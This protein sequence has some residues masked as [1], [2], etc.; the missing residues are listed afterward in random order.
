MTDDEH[1][2]TPPLTLRRDAAVRLFRAAMWRD[3]AA[4]WER[5]TT[6]RQVGRE[7]M[8]SVG[9]PDKAECIRRAKEALTHV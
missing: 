4:S 8:A 7:W 1:Q 2:T 6:S 3:Y 9:M 5:P